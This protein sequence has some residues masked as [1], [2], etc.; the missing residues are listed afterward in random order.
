MKKIGKIIYWL[1]LGF[2]GFCLLLSFS[3]DHIVVYGAS[4]EPTLFEYEVALS[5]KY[6]YKLFGIDRFDIVV[7]NNVD[8]TNNED[9]SLLIKRV[10]GLP[11]EKI[12]YEDSKLYI[13]DEYVAESFIDDDAKTATASV[14]APGLTNHLSEG[15]VTLGTD[16]YFVMGDNRT[17]SY[18][19]RFFTK[20]VTLDMIVSK[21]L[22]IYGN[23]DSCS[24]VTLS[25]GVSVECTGY[26]FI[27]PEFIGW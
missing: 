20:A 9:E 13:N 6:L 17:N 23:Y 10:I 8:L 11:G 27:W 7:I 16:E 26:N 3:M 14:Y 21:G 25:D 2:L 5:D 18:D 19:S 1:V 22:I 15:S 12:T 24:A 4:M